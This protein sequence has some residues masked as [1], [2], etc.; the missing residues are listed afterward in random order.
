MGQLVDMGGFPLAGVPQIVN[1]RTG[2]P[3]GL[4]SVRDD[5]TAAGGEGGILLDYPPYE[6]SFNLSKNRAL[7]LPTEYTA[8]TPSLYILGAPA[9]AGDIF[10][11]EYLAASRFKP[12]PSQ[13]NAN[14]AY[15]A[16]VT[17]L[18]HFNGANGSTSFPDQK[19]NS[20]TVG[21]GA[22]AISTT[23]SKYAG[24][25]VRFNGVSRLTATNASTFPFGTGDFTVEGYFYADTISTAFQALWFCT[26]YAIYINSST[27]IWYEGGAHAA[28]ITLSSATWYHFAVTRQGTT[29][30]LF[31]NGTKSTT[32]FTTSTNY[33]QT[34]YSLGANSANGE[35]FTG[36]MADLR[37]TKGVARYIASFTAP[38]TQFLNQ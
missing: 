21:T 19:G 11:I 3:F 37:V 20:W 38:T 6:G 14:D 23:Q 22:P 29:L 2:A 18:L 16:F 1:P 7:Q 34:V 17:S 27:L 15:Y 24:S 28:S 31:V 5:L 12:R 36:Y 25:S 9:T 30:R 4:H 10:T 26:G 33:S 32:D 8:S 13:F 35:L